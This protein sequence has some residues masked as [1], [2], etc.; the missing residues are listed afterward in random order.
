MMI[1]T[2]KLAFY[3]DEAWFTFS[4]YLK[5]QNSRCWSTENP[6]GGHEVPVGDVKVGTW[7]AVKS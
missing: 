2:Q 6:H 5:N 3:Y 4:G 7:R 1:L